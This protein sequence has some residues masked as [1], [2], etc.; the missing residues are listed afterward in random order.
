MRK[1]AM[2]IVVLFCCTI[3][4][5]A[6][7][8]TASGQVRDDKGEPIPFATVLEKGTKNGTKADANGNFTFK[9]NEG[10]ELVVSATG[11]SDQTAKVGAGAVNVALTTKTSALQEVVVTTALGQ[12]RQSKE[13]GYSTAKVKSAELT[14]AKVVNLQNG[15]TGKVSGLNVNTTNSGVFGD[16]RI[17]LRGIRSLTGNN[18][19][20]LVLDGVPLSLGFISSINPNDI[21]DVTILKS[22]SSTAI[23]GPDGVNGAIVITTKKGS[24]GRPAVTVSH[25][26]QWEKVSYLPKFQTQFGGGYSPDANGYGTFEPIEQQSWGDAFDG[27]I[28]QFGQT[29]PNGEKLEMPYSYNPNGRRNFY[30]TGITNQ[31]DLSFSTG[32][33]Y[34]SAQNVNIKGTM[35]GDENAR[36][37]INLRADKEYG[38]FKA[39]FGIRYTQ[40]QYNVT[41]N[42]QIVYYGVTSAPGNYDLARFK[43]WRNDYFS[44]PDGFYSPYLDNNGKTPYFAK[45]NYREIGRG[46]EFFG[47]GQLDFKA[48]SWL[49]FT[50]RVG[51]TYDNA[52]ARTT[53][54]AF[55]YSAFHLTLRD[56]GTRNITAATSNA[57]TINRRLTSEIFASFNKRFG[58]VGLNALVGQSY[59]ESNFKFVSNGAPNL[60]NATLLSIQLR[61]GEPTVGV[62]NSTTRLERY[63][64]KVSFDY[65]NWA[66]LEA[67]GSYDMDSRLVKPN[68]NFSKSDI[69]F[70]Y[71]GVSASVLLHEVIPGLKSNNFVNYVKVRGAVSKTGNVNLT[72][73]NYQN[74]Y[75]QSLFFPYGDILGFQASSTINDDSYEPEFVV[76]KEV[77]VEL[78][79][80]KNR[81]NFEA[82]YYH[83]TNTNQVI[84]IQLSGTT[85]SPAANGAVTAT[86]NAASFNNKGYELDLKLTPL[87]QIRKVNIDFKVN[88]SRQMNK[89]TSLI[90]GVNEIGLGNYNYAIV[91]Q[92]AYMFKLTD[93][94]RD[95][96]GRV[97]VDRASGM[98][99]QNSN[100]SL[101]GKTN[102]EH[103]LGLGLNVSWK[104]LTFSAVADYRA[105]SQMV[106]DQLGAF[107]DDNGISERSAQNGRRAFIF[108]N[109]VYDDGT[110]KYVANTDVYTT[111]YGRL[112]WNSDLNTNVISNYVADASFW[113]LREVAVSYEIPVKT[114]GNK[115]SN[116]I[117]GLTV[118]LT[119]RNLLMWVPKSN[120]W[121]DP[122]FAGGNG[123][124]S[125]TGNATGRSTAYN[126]PPT[127]L[128]GANVVVRF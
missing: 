2:L 86:R 83:Q 31:T 66:F 110:G 12:T 61:K 50:Y 36:R 23:Y 116:V 39:G 79:F 100:L 94:I 21:A 64:G 77:G 46:D 57:N 59:R 42:N 122:E 118:S 76:N 95:N 44:S 24:K 34:I 103:Y 125:Y 28:R 11:F 96:Q 14:Q 71:P 27:S 68:T 114:L 74:V 20:M 82:T 93:Y 5:F 16:T 101:F 108:P 52:E 9:V 45:D 75:N 98:P 3:S 29:G 10:A 72:A 22:S 124:A 4:A 48:T 1:I 35:P 26:T 87:V 104:G 128:F 65:N 6:Q 80:L 33:F 119:G 113:K 62:D 38:K 67:T 88:Y 90:D 49:N 85:G 15:L 17:T 121:T 127:R 25:T 92:S 107:L 40:S 84:D 63:F 120:V 32:D 78:G 60:G 7:S 13:L 117:K 126:A 30:A 43:D 8:R 37:S 111:N 55:N 54:G 106:A 99:T 51:F 89:I 91:G 102:P 58:N 53:R 115:F 47:T 41:N 123:N 105:G 81:I 97:I 19:P 69:A 18:Q 70:F 73:Y 109:S 56:H 112:F